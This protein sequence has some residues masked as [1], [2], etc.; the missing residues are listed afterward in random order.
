VFIVIP[1]KAFA[2]DVVFDFAVAF[3]VA[4]EALRVLYYPNSSLSSSSVV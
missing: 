4:L 1:I 3:V 2:F